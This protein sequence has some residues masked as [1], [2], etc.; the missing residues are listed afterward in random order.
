MINTI[1]NTT[2]RSHPVL[3][4]VNMILAIYGIAAIEHKRQRPNIAEKAMI[5]SFSLR[6]F[7][8]HIPPSNYIINIQRQS[9]SEKNQVACLFLFSL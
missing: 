3:L 5:S 6:S 2:P 4:N 1:V 8:S 7:I 9:P